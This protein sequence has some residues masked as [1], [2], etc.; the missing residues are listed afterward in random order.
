MYPER[1]SSDENAARNILSSL[2][3]RV[4]FLKKAHSLLFQ[5]YEMARPIL[6]QQQLNV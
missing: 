6:H 4:P 1:N 5:V 3:L 2:I